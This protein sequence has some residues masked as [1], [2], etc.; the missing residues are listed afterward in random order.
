[1]MKP[2]PFKEAKVYMSRNLVAP[3][4]FDALL[5]ALK[6]NGA[7]VELCCD[8]SRTGPNDFH[9]ISS[10][11]HEKFEDLRA[12]GCNLLGPQ[13]VL[14][15]AKEN[16]ALPKQGFTCCLAMDGVKVIASGFDVDEKFK[17]EKLVTAMGGVLQTKA[18]LDVSFVIV[19]NVLAAKYKWA[20]NILKKPIVTVNWLYQ[21]WNEH[22]V[23]PQESYKVLPFSGL[24][25]CVTRIP[26]DERKEMEKLIVQ[27][28]GKYSPELTKK[29]THLI[30]DISFT[31][32]F[33]NF[34][35]TPEGDKFK[36]AKRWGHIHIINR[37]W[38]DQSM[39]RRACLNEESYTVQD[40]SVSSKKT[41]MGSLTK[42]HSQVKVIGNAL[43]APSSMATESNLLS[44][45]CTGFAD[46]D[47][48]ATCSQSMP[49]M[50]MDAPVVSK[51]GAIEAPTAQTRN[52][53]NS[54]VCVAN[55]SQ[56][57]DNDLYLSDCRIVLVGF[58]ASEMRKLVNMVRRGGGSR[59]VSYNNGLTHI[60][61]GT[62]SEADKREV[63]SL[64][65]L[66]II[67]VV[68]STWLEDCD[69]ERREISILQ[70]HVAYDLLLP[71]ES[72]WSTKGAPLCRNN[73]N[74]GKESSVRHS[75]SSD[76]ML[77]STNS[78]IGMPLSL[79]E[80]REERAEIHM[81][82][83]SSLEATAVPSQ[84]NLLSALSDENKTQLRTK[85]DFRVQSLQNMKLSTVFRGKIFRF[86]NSFPE[87][88]RA[89]IVQWVNQGR[90]EVVNDDA[91]QNV[92]FTIECH[93]VIPKSADASETTYDG[94]LLDVGSHILYSPLHCQT[95][96]PGF[97][98]F[99]FCVSQYEE[100]DRL[101]LRNLC[102]V[103]GA[104]FMEKLTKKVTH[105]LCKFAGGLKYE[106][107]CKWGIPSITS[108]WIYECVRQNEV[109]SLDPFSPKEVTTHDREAGLCTV[110]QFPMQAVQ[111]SSADEPS[112]FIN[113]LG[114]LQSTSPQTMVHKIDDITRSDNLGDEANQ[115]SAHNKRARISEDEDHDALPGVHL[116]DP[117]R[118]INY[119]GD[120]MSKDNGEVPHIGSDVAAVIED[121]VEQTSK[122]QDLKSPERTLKK[123]DIQNP[124]NSKGVRSG[125]YEP[126]SET[127]TES[128]VVSY[129]EDL[130][131]RQKIIDRA[132]SEAACLEKPHAITALPMPSPTITTPSSVPASDNLPAIASQNP[133]DTG[134]PIELDAKDNLPREDKGAKT[135]TKE[136]NDEFTEAKQQLHFRP[137]RAK[138]Q[139]SWMRDYATCKVYHQPS[140]ALDSPQQRRTQPPNQKLYHS[141]VTAKPSLSSI[142]P[143]IRFIR[144]QRAHLSNQHPQSQPKPLPGVRILGGFCWR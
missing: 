144:F 28:G 130:S 12:K 47:L 133:T 50:Y 23:V 11:D 99:R 108:E 97:E 111:M 57:E 95:P 59:Y 87:D 125:I 103:L 63:R 67:Q 61:V 53:S 86:S 110:S 2:K 74:Q 114:G 82:R 33:L 64:A 14:S 6:L 13:C 109:V 117:H 118:N 129:E 77:R 120:S 18:T 115:T 26:A 46:Q 141:F 134:L 69:R 137:E 54:D 56:S 71:K 5:D 24:M 85:E 127:Q 16:R 22:R 105:L 17:I 10:S 39:A 62:L 66:G 32:Y 131:G 89:E 91:K 128:Q 21:C 41:V 90:G 55:D 132:K 44:V 68:K 52:E 140:S 142:Q 25:I 31:I 83:E 35:Y 119:N 73:L 123:N 116:K 72:A 40:S 112:Q 43:P 96:L 106:A 49:S 60:V 143:T 94:C 80:N 79:E 98:R 121:L 104:K 81:K 45:S 113:P 84:Q 30:C 9:V 92:H 48:E 102:F 4:I 70:R 20:L 135:V 76:E 8:P 34:P 122:V 29:C 7:E 124:F 15:C 136:P 42:Q 139:P 19:K 58:E 37:K 138:K 65:S 126:F 88:R 27:N 107:A 101:L 100:K 93:S 1:M 51:D 36:V 75:L 38:F 78:G 3:E